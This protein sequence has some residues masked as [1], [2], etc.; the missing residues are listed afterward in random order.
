MNRGK[1]FLVGTPI[2]N[3]EDITLRAL[4][5]LKEV[6]VILCEDTTRSVKLLNHYDIKKPLQSYYKPKEKEKLNLVL[7]WLSEGKS[8]ALISD[9]GMPLISDP[10]E[11]LV[12]TV[13]EAGYDIESVPGPSS[14]I[15]ALSLSGFYTER[16]I[17]EGFL[18]KKTNLKKKRLEEI[19]E[20]PHTTIFF[21]P[22]RELHET[23]MLI[24]EVFGERRICVARELTKLHQEV[25][26]TSVNDLLKEKREFRGEVTLVVEGWKEGQKEIDRESL[27]AIF[28]NEMKKGR[29][30]K[31][32][33]KDGR[34]AGISKN[35]LYDLWEEVKDG[36]GKD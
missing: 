34:I 19:K 4:R 11:L 7:K 36:E 6:D 27:K 32:L 12:K 21:V 13:K 14:V 8:L 5:V 15:T 26:T 28:K 33:L 16:F 20:L 23:A 25:I 10:G 22:A 24:K 31:D 3:L 9:A 18:P 30:F 2:G 17:F 1:L 29:T 35:Y